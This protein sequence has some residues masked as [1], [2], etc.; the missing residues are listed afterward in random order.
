MLELVRFDPPP[1]AADAVPVR[2]GHGHVAFRVRDLAATQAAVEALGARPLGE[3]VRFTT[4]RAVYL[5]EPAGSVFELYE[6]AA[7]G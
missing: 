6:P 7:G 1:G 4:G 2:V 5:R 3:A